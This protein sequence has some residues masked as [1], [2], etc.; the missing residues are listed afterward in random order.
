MPDSAHGTNPA[1][2][3]MAGFQVVNLPSDEA[4]CV[5]LGKLQEAVGE[6]TAGLMLTNPNTLGIFG[7]EHSTDYRDCP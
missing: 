4:G 2:A 6:D 1:S 3:V 5:D 7:Q